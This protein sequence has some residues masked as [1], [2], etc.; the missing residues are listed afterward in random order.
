[1][2]KFMIFYFNNLRPH[3]GINQQT[4]LGYIPETEGKIIQ[5]PVLGG[6]WHHYTRVAA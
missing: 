3:Q 1:M 2:N 6:L 4:P 5:V